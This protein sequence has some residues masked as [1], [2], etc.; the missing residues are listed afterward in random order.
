MLINVTG[1]LALQSKG[2]YSMQHRYQHPPEIYSNQIGAASVFHICL[3]P[4][5]FFSIRPFYIKLAYICFAIIYTITLPANTNICQEPILAL[6]ILS[7]PKTL[8]Y[9]SNE[10]GF[11]SSI[12][13]CIFFTS[14]ILPAVKTNR[15]TLD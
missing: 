9:T 6:C 11:Y 14:C 3:N 12:I 10:S 1:S 15:V 13:A 5:L 2:F 8:P 4:P 7:V